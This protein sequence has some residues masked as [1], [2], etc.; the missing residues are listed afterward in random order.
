MN[1]FYVD[2]KFLPADEATIPVTDLSVLRGFGVFDFMRTY[3]GKPFHLEDHVK[4]LERSADLLSI[5]LPLS[6]KE[7]EDLILETLKRNS[8][9]ESNIRIVLT[10]GISADGFNPDGKPRLLVMITPL[11]RMPESWYKTGVKIVTIPYSR[12]MPGAKSINYVHAIHAMQKARKDG[13]IEALYV[14]SDGYATECTTSNI[15]ACMNG[16]LV[17]P[18]NTILPGI[19][20]QV[21]LNMGELSG[22]IQIKDIKLD[23]L[24]D[25]DEVFIT[26]S[27]KEVA[28]VVDIDGRIIGKGRPGER[29]RRVMKLFSEYTLRYAVK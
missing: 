29:T 24:L 7:V 21:V 15:F 17:T 11:A 5:P 27:N 6:R 23:T 12:F 25:A 4:R 18:G 22:A 1:I 13:A 8:N 3:G 2:G 20:R 16:K 28:P 19:T 14:T 10:G 9:E 26:S